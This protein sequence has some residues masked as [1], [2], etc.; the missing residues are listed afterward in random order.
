MARTWTVKTAKTRDQFKADHFNEPAHAIAGQFNGKLDQHNMPLDSVTHDDLLDPVYSDDAYGVDTKS[1]YMPTQSYHVAVWDIDSTAGL[2][3]TEFGTAV[4]ATK[5]I[6][7]NWNAKWNTFPASPV[8]EGSRLKFNAKEGMIFGGV[9]ASV[10]RREGRARDQY[11]A[12]GNIGSEF[13]IGAENWHELGVFV[14]GIL[15]GRTGELNCGS[16]TVDIPYSTPIGTE[17]CEVQL[18]WMANQLI[19]DDGAIASGN[20]TNDA[21]Q[22][23]ICSGMQLWARNQYR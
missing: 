11:G 10:E 14:N 4:F 22:Y 18:K 21:Y 16:Y 5:F 2:D 1:S 15:C 20:A 3:T 8:T 7:T 12:G 13:N 17:F 6:D 23:Y 9:T 19:F